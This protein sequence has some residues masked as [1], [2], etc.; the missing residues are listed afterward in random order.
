MSTSDRNAYDVL[1]SFNQ[2]PRWMWANRE[3]LDLIEWLREYNTRLPEEQKV[4]F[5][6]LDVY[7]LWESLDAVI[8]YLKKVDPQAVQTAIQL[9]ILQKGF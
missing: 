1:Y 8:K 9:Q 7:N 2:W 4:G 6:G 5:Y 3:I